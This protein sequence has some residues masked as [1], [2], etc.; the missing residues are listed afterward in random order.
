MEAKYQTKTNAQLNQ[1]IQRVKNYK[2]ILKALEKRMFISRSNQLRLKELLR[3]D[4][5]LPLSFGYFHF[6]T[7]S[8]TFLTASRLQNFISTDPSQTAL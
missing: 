4:C 2:K 5:N 6:F 8:S 7:K 3:E 1:N